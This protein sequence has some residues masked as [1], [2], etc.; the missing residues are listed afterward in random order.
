MVEK[1]EGSQ[2]RVKRRNLTEGRKRRSPL[3]K[4]TSVEKKKQAEGAPIDTTAANRK[5]RG[6]AKQEGG[7]KKK[8]RVRVSDG[9]SMRKEGYA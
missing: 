3:G 1:K 8:G 4:N 5:K 6:N 7:R 9:G 2:E